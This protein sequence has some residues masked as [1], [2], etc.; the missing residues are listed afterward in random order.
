MKQH[1]LIIAE[2]GVN[3][4]G[5]IEIA[6]RMVEAAAKAGADIVKFQTGLP[7]KTIS[8]F[9]VKADYQKKNTHDEGG[10]ESQIDMARK[11][12]LQWEDY[13]ELL[14]CCK[15]NGIQFLSTSFDIESAIF[16]K[17]LGQKSWKIPSGE[18]TNLPLL[19]HVAH[20]GEPIIMS[21]GMCRLEEVRDAL[22]VLDREGAGEITL[23]QCNTQ[24][25][26]PYRDANLRAMLTLQNEFG[27]KV[28]YSDHTLGIEVSLAAVAMGATVIEKH[29]TLDRNMEGPDQ[30]ASIEPHEL[31]ALVSGIRNIEEAMGT[32]IKTPSASEIEN[33]P[34]ARKSI[35]AAR[36]IRKGEI[37]CEENLACKRPGD[38]ISPMLWDQ[39]CGTKAV[40]DFCYDEKIEL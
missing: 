8:I 16:L 23:M 22:A 12:N 37:L 1:T 39:V 33:M 36:D 3:Y 21:T 17:S 2:A 34:I 4:N 29:F 13:P 19:R 32:G 27:R 7:E 40:R 35:V 28:G 26:T 11:L 31:K 18:V 6:K 30:V 9:A 20:Y 10:E 14:Q 25:P 5:S 38:G 24:Y 15:D